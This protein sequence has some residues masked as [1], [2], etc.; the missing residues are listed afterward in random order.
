MNTQ[1]QEQILRQPLSEF[2]EEHLPPRMAGLFI[3]C[4]H[5]DLEWVPTVQ[6]IFASSDPYR[7]L[8]RFRGIGKVATDEI[9]KK[10]RK[11]GFEITGPLHRRMRPENRARTL[12]WRNK[13]LAMIDD[14]IAR[15]K[16]RLPKYHAQRKELLAEIAKLQP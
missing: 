16:A 15:H 14:K 6:T 5:L 4:S 7:E 2:I 1:I 8:Y 3:K 10:L 12:V 11:L 9:V 13:Q